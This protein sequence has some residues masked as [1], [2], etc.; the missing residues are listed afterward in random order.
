MMSSDLDAAAVA[1][2]EDRIANGLLPEYAIST[3]SLIAQQLEVILE[4]AGDSL[5]HPVIRTTTVGALLNA[6][7]DIRL[8][9]EATAHADLLLPSAPSEQLWEALRAVFG[10]EEPNPVR[11]VKGGRA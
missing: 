1:H 9:D 7:Y 10:P 6:G 11:R 8:T 2:Y 5:A 3:A 4:R